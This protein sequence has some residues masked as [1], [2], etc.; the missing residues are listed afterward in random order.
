MICEKCGKEM[1]KD[2]SYC[3][4]CSL[5]ENSTYKGYLKSLEVQE[6]NNNNAKVTTNNY[7]NI[8]SIN[9]TLPQEGYSTNN[10]KEIETE[11]KQDEEIIISQNTN[12][13]EMAEFL[14]IILNI[15]KFLVIF[16][17]TTLGSTIVLMVP[18]LALTG[19][20]PVSGLGG[21]FLALIGGTIIGFILAV[22]IM[23]KSLSKKNPKN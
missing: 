10:K 9:S 3:P 16:C 23:K 22:I 11:K 18:F 4:T 21:T 17:L 12:K 1:P 19:S 20:G 2:I 13:E 5:N 6:K 7:A 15:V 14:K 8:N